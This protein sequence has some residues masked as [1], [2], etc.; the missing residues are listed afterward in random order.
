MILTCLREKNIRNKRLC[1][2][3]KETKVF[4][5]KS[6]DYHGGTG[7]GVTSVRGCVNVKRGVER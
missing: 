1:L 3:V 4:Q 7:F 2:P 6:S 5:T